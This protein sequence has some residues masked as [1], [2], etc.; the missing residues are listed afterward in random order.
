MDGEGVEPA[1]RSVGLRNYPFA[2]R[3][4]NC[5]FR[6]RFAVINDL[7][8][9]LVELVHANGC[10]SGFAFSIFV[11]M[12]PVNDTVLISGIERKE[13]LAGDVS[14]F[15]VGF[16]CRTGGADKTERSQRNG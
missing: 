10:L 2:K 6:R 11:T 14:D 4:M 15:F 16:V 12:E 7:F 1:I 8:D 13:F 3:F 5:F 9:R